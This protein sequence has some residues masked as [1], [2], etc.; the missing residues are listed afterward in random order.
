MN[1]PIRVLIFR[2]YWLVTPVVAALIGRQIVVESRPDNVPGNL[3]ALCTC[4]LGVVYFIQKQ[5]SD[6]LLIFEK[7]FTQF[8]QRYAELPRI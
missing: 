4:A 8:N 1:H 6:D 7:L 3:I 2:Y 5:K